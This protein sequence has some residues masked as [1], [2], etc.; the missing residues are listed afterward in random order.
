MKILADITNRAL[1]EACEAAK[2]YYDQREELGLRFEATLEDVI[3][4]IVAHPLRFSEE[5]NGIRLAPVLGFPYAIYYRIRAGR[6]RVVAV[7]HQSRDPAGW[8]SR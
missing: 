3:E 1:A 7:F 5:A 2:W 8:Q 4:E 6:P